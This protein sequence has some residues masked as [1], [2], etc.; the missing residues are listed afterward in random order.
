MVVRYR[1]NSRRRKGMGMAIL[2]NRPHDQAS[3]G[4]RPCV[5]FE[6]PDASYPDSSSEK[7]PPFRDPAGVVIL[8]KIVERLSNR[9]YRTTKVKPALG[10]EAG[11]RCRLMD[12]SNIQITLGVSRRQGGLVACD[13]ITYYSPSMRDRWRGSSASTERVAE[14]N[15]LCETINEA[16]VGVLHATSVLWLTEAEA[17]E[18]WKKEG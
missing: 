1:D 2:K 7:R 18:R 9:G 4:L 6:L 16:I 17:S 12:D 8:R 15:R 10:I 11:C 13:L 14:W 5:Y 3:V